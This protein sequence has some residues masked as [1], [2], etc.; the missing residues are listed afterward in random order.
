MKN[1]MWKRSLPAIA[2]L[3]F[4]TAESPGA[5]AEKTL[6]TAATPR[7]E[8]KAFTAQKGKGATLVRR[9]LEQITLDGIQADNL[10]L[11]SVVDMLMTEAQKRDPEHVGVNFLLKQFV[12]EVAAV[13]PTTGL[14]MQAESIDLGSVTI[15]IMPGL[16]N[17]RLIDALNAIVKVAD[18]P[19]RYTIEDYGVVITQGTRQPGASILE[20]RTFQISP[21]ENFY[22]GIESTFGIQVPEAVDSKGVRSRETQ[23]QIFQELFQQV[24]IE[25]ESPKSIFF[26]ELNGIIMVRAAQEDMPLIT[27]TMQTLGGLPTPDPT[28]TRTI[29]RK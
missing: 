22:K 20:T 5:D 10:P 19:L 4:M 17:I 29:S 7:T 27:A 9:K 16:R 15:R 11:V 23:Q 24:G 8:A 14:P 2:L 6:K 18:R 12:Y 13:D 1:P 3:A 25:W 28:V 26:N 21:S